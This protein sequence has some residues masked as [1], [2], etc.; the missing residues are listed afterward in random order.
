MPSCA[1][2]RKARVQPR[3]RIYAALRGLR[4]PAAALARVGLLGMSVL[5]V[6]EARFRE[7]LAAAGLTVL[8]VRQ[9]DDENFRYSRYVVERVPG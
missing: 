8:R 4:V 9:G 3:Y 1:L 7:V 6:P 5:V 2:T